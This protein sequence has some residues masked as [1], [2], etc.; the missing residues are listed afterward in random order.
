MF[1]LSGRFASNEPN[2]NWAR[3]GSAQFSLLIC[4]KL[5]MTRIQTLHFVPVKLRSFD[6]RVR[7][8]P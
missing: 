2:K 7:T 5:V 8:E 3:F 4:C 6:P 1:K